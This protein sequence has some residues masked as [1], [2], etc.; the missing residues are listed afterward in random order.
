MTPHFAPG[1]ARAAL[2]IK[3]PGTKIRGF[4]GQFTV[5]N[6]QVYSDLQRTSQG[7]SIHDGL[8]ESWKE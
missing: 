7:N 8:Y 4:R 1:V 5:H 3:S 6:E 2:E